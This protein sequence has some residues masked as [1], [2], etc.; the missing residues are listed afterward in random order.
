MGVC[1]LRSWLWCGLVFLM[2]WVGGMSSGRADNSLFGGLPSADHNFLRF[3]PTQWINLSV[4]VEEHFLGAESPVSGSTIG[5]LTVLPSIV[6]QWPALRFRPYINAGLGLGIGGFTYDTTSI[7]LSLRFEERLMLKI[8]G[9]I[10]Y[11]LGKGFSLTGSTYFSQVKTTNLL[12]HFST[13]SFPL[14]QDD[15]DV[16]AHTV[17]LG[18]RLVY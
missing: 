2:V 9:G 17:E 3:S 7:P 1:R 5:S 14:V 13:S 11:D 6:V 15:L 12:S 8:G 16:N 4:D 18:I 10:A